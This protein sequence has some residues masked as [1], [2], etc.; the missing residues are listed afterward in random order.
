[1][2]SIGSRGILSGGTHRVVPFRVTQS[3]GDVRIYGRVVNPLV[4]TEK[5]RR[6]DKCPCGSGKKFKKCHLPQLG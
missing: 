4:L 3:N 6:N 1:M 2:Y 5:T